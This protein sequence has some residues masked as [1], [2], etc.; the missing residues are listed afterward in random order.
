MEGRTYNGKPLPCDEYAKWSKSV[1]GEA[2]LK[3]GDLSAP[4]C[5]NCHGNHGA[6]PPQVDSVAN[7]C[8]TCHGKIAKLF[9][10][11]KMR[12]KFEVEHLPGCAA[13]HSNHEIREPTDDFLGMQ[14]RRILRPLPRR[15]ERSSTAPRPPAPRPPRPSMPIS[16]RLKDGIEKAE[17]TLAEAE[18]KGH[19]GQPARSSISTRPRMRSPTPAP[20]SIAS[21]STWSRRPWPMARRFDRPRRPRQRRPGQGRQSPGGI[22]TPP[23]LAGDHAG[24]DPDGHRAAGALYPQLADPR[25]SGGRITWSI[26]LRGARR[27]AGREGK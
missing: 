17:E 18:R 23:L 24:A 6:A 15:R 26:S 27:G 12:H 3:K 13:C 2:L 22:H 25:E 5:N 16:Q 19:G 14:E 9:E 11:T 4:T 7:A 21:K 10:D 20:R 8:G 1:H